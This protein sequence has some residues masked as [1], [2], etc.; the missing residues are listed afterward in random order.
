MKSFL[1][2]FL[3][4][5]AACATNPYAQ[6]YTDKT[7]GVDIANSGR[8]MIP[9]GDP[10]VV[11]GSDRQKDHIRMLEEGYVLLGLSS[12]NGGQVDENDAVEHGKQIH[13]RR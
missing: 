10:L 9:T 12:F 13:A 1:S 5:M 4:L 6:F 2:I 7:K 3:L 8:F 11:R